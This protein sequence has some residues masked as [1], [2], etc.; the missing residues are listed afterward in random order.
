V[1]ELQVHLVR[2]VKRWRRVGG[3]AGRQ[4]ETAPAPLLRNLAD[5]LIYLQNT[6]FTVGAD[7]AT[8]VEDRWVGMPFVGAAE[9]GYLETLIDALNDPLP[10][11]KDFILPV[12]IPW[13][14]RASLPVVCRRAEREVETLAAS[15]PVGEF[16]RPFLNRLSDLFFVMARRTAQEMRQCSAAAAIPPEAIWRR[17]LPQPPLFTDRDR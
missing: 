13:L 6:L 10:P 12:V 5:H 8:R 14:R 15:E 4:P 9:V 11:L 16:M 3:V 1:D 2:R 17:D 7:L